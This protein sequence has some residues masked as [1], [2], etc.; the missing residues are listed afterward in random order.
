VD[1]QHRLQ[2][3]RRA[4]DTA[5]LALGAVVGLDQGNKLVPRNDALHLV[6]KLALARALG[7]QIKTQIGLLHRRGSAAVSLLASTNQ[8]AY[9]WTGF[10]EIP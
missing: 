1:S 9:R 2:L 4:A 3:E 6:E 5:G 8:P 7:T 10:A